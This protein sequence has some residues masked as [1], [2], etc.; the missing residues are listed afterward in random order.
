MA[1]FKANA[2]FKNLDG[3]TTNRLFLIQADHI[4]QAFVK[5]FQT[6][7]TEMDASGEASISCHTET[8]QIIQ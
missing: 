7:G 2:N 6:I 5:L 1:L 8:I 4:R 3:T